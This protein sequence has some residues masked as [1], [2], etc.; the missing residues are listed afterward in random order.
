MIYIRAKTDIANTLLRIDL[1]DTAGFLTTQASLTKLLDTE[2]SILEYDFTGQYFDGGFGG[3]SCESADAPCPVDPTTIGTILFYPNPADGGF[4]GCIEIDFISFGAPMGEDIEPY[5]DE[6][7]ND[8]SDQWADA[9]GFTVEETGGELILTGDGT[10]G[11][12]TSFNYTTHDTDNNTPKIID[13]TSNNKLYVKVK[14]TTAGVPLRI[15]LV[16]QDGFASTEP[17]TLVTKY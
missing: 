8:N 10:S 7:D 17:A 6:F 11:A 12:Y 13:M 15:D 14:S 9:A 3:T 5:V 1:V 4:D 16:D 2:F